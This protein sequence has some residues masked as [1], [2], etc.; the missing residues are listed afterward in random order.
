MVALVDDEDFARL[1]TVKWYAQPNKSLKKGNILYY[2]ARREGF[3]GP[4]RWMHREVA[5]TPEQLFTDHINGDT[6]DNRRANLRV[7]T[8]QQNSFNQAATKAWKESKFKGVRRT[9]NKYKCWGAFIRLNGKTMSLGTYTSE[10]EAAKSY[11]M[12]AAQLFGEFAR[13][14]QV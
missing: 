14:N 11:N 10:K 9:R 4:M 8:H 7:V 5:G 6:L 12:A 13:L 2:A 3:R 1:N